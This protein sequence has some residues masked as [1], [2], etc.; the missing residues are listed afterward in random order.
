MQ[1]TQISLIQVIARVTPLFWVVLG[2]AVAI[3]VGELALLVFAVRRGPVAN[4]GGADDRER[5][6]AVWFAV[7]A[8]AGPLVLAVA[9]TASI[10]VGHTRLFAGLASD[11][12]RENVALIVAGLEGFLN[13]KPWG[14]MVLI[15]CVALATITAAL[16]A[17][18]AMRLPPRPIVGASLTFASAGLGPFLAGAFVY[19]T[20]VIKILAGVA[21]V[22]PEMKQLMITKGLEE[23]RAALDRGAAIGAVGFA[24]A[25]IV[26]IA[27]AVN[28]RKLS[29]A[30]RI[31]WWQPAAC[32]LVAGALW[33]AAEP[34]RAENTT[35]WPGSPSAALT[36]NRVATPAV[37][38]PDVIPRAEVVTVGNDLLLSDGS[39]RNTAELHDTL[40]VMRNNYVLL[41]PSE[42]PDESLVIVCAPDTRTAALIDVLRVA[43]E[44]K[45]RRPAFAFGKEVTIERPMMGK[46]R[47]WQWTA[48][49]ALIPGVGPETPTSV[50][51]LNVADYPSCDG[52]ARAVAAV[53]RR[54]AIAGLAF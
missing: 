18:S 24:A 52:V 50:V 54:G 51:S 45:Y 53:R 3:G 26:G 44:V 31:R 22:D 43:K 34:L 23:A 20:Q 15:P 39:P 41:H 30:G 48:A 42:L 35:P 32:L 36:I 17:A 38:G 21:G 19:S 4:Q 28:I 6:R 14:L 27:T 33:M 7:A 29:G 10:H 49:K 46:L 25:L 47:R 12:P 11:H 40:V 2:V 1:E 8:A 13:A 5:R 9:V 37:D 16:H